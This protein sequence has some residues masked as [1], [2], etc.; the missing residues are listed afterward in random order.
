MTETFDIAIVGAG[1]TGCAIARQLA[2]FDLSICVV[3]AT[4]DIALGASKANGGLV[5]A[6]YD[7]APG[8]VKAQVNARGCEL[9]GTWAQELGFLFRRTGSMVLGFNDEDRAHLEQ[10]RSNGLANGV[11]ELSIIGPDRIHELEV[12]ASAKATCA[13]WCPS[14]GFVDPFE[15]AIAALENAVANGVTFMRSAS[16]EAI[17]VA[18]SG[19]DARFTLA[20]PAGEV[21]CRYIINAAGN[22]AADIS[23]M[24]GAEEF[25]MIWRQGNIVVL[26]KEPR[27]LM[28]LYPVPTP[29]SKGVIV[30]G[31]VHGNTVITATA[32]VREP[33]DTQTYASD[34]DAL[35]TG[36]RKLVPDLDT[37]RV[38]R[39]FAGGRPVIQGT[40][41]F[42]IGQS[43]VVPGLFQAAGIQSPG[44]ASAPAIAERMEQVM[45]DA[46]VVLRE[47]DDWNPIRR[48]PDDF[49]RAPLARKEELIESDPA[50]GQIVCRCETVPEAEIVAAIR[51]R[52]GAVSVEGVKRRC[53]A[54]MGR[55][56]SGFCQSRVVAIL[57]RELGCD[58]NEVLLEDAGSWLVEGP[59]KGGCARMAKLK[60]SATDSG[61]V[62]S[63][64]TQA[65]DV[66]V[67]GGGPA[68][69]A[70]ALAA[71]KAGARVA[72]VERE[73]HL[74]GI[75]RQCIHPGFGLSHFK[76]ELTGPEYAQRFI[77]QVHAT[78]I[79]LFLNSMVIGID[80]GECASGADESAEDGVTHTVTLMSRDGMLQL[81]G[82]AVVLAMG[83]RERT[84]SEIK[85]PG[86]RPAG[87][88]TAGLAQ[89]YINIENLKPGSRA[90]ILGSGDIGL[91]MARRCTLEGISVEGVYELMPY[92]NGLRRN[93]KN[94]LDDF[95]I[96][97]HLSTTVT[98]VIG[99]DRVEAV[100]VSQVDEHL[101]PIAGTER[102]VPCDTLLLSVGLIPE[103]ELSVAAGVELDPRTRGAVVDQ[104]LQTGVPGIFACGNV[105]H[106]HDLADNVTTESERAGAAAATYALG[107][108]AGAVPN[109]EL[110]VSP[111][112]IA[113]Y[114][115]PGRITAVALTKLNFRVRR[116][117]DAARVRIL[118]GSEELFAGK[119]RAFKPSVMESFPLPAKVI[120]RALDLGAREIILSV[121]PI[122]EA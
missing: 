95:G 83:C 102:I 38:V 85:I 2:R 3:E 113:G 18:S 57:A 1:I 15:V 97:L 33:G 29:V 86:S 116:P 27:T 24:A 114:A 19:D 13:L 62:E 104:S 32:A 67:I 41:D 39:A 88:F 106:V 77:D 25:Q 51:R 12:R 55:C 93:V 50:W 120:Q 112:G 89:R 101:A 45:R 36:A 53:R 96:P 100:E 49:D 23:H 65:F 6:G 115:L 122:E 17:E 21:H 43:A 4:N 81:T 58:P 87:V 74:G 84:R 71:H 94:C 56:Q 99:H 47:R 121:D 75:L 20:T 70:A 9:Y 52:P 66:V 103:N 64:P 59:L 54:G 34:V 108:G 26:D 90:V 117:V 63:V 16:V 98:R 109:C 78:D 69:M 82:C 68:G 10:L 30:T 40:N 105:L 92:A 35:L 60:S 42:F 72:I 76:Q 11:P 110:T 119:V 61:A 48:A 37:R 107:T 73:Q 31:T 118:A 7:P 91:I 28:P 111:A 79:V 44:V 14:T 5:H 8:T 80:S 46:G 22:G